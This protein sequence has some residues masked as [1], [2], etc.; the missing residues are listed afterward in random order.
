MVKNSFVAR[1]YQRNGKKSFFGHGYQAARTDCPEK[2]YALYIF[3]EKWL[4]LITKK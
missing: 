2:N 3:L 4:L 1:L